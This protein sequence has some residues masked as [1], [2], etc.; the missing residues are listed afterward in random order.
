MPYVITQATE[1]HLSALPEIELL[2][3]RL[4]AG[5]ELPQTILEETTPLEEL[6]AAMHDG[7]LWVALAAELPVGFAHAELLGPA[8]HLEELDVHPA[9]GRR[10]L[11]RALVETVCACARAQG[12][13]AVT[14]TTFRD[15]PWNAP[16]YQR[17]GFHC[18]PAAALSP[19][20]QQ[21][22]DAEAARGLPAHRRV[23]MIKQV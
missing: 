1:A 23:V 8:L 19:E 10:G 9:H 7:Y 6:R 20:L 18:I 16:F 4:F 3:A 13:E 15:V 14:L 12:R 11:G 21:R 5:Y 17:L 22:V 2:A